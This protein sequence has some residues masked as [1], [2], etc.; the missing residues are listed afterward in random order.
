MASLSDR[1]RR[2]AVALCLPA[3]ERVAQ[4]LPSKAFCRPI[5][6]LPKKNRV[7]TAHFSPIAGVDRSARNF[8]SPHFS[9]KSQ[10]ADS[11]SARFAVIVSKKME[12]TAVGRNKIKRRMRAALSPFAK[13]AK[14]SVNFVYAKKGAAAISFK[15]IQKEIN[16]LLTEAKIV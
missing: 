1:K 11:G 5:R 12:K 14:P 3:E 4:S 9:F 16:L 6:M 8:H 2:P 15:E 13:H 10:K 7:R